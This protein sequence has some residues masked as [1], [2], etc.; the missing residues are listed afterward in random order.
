MGSGVA[1]GVAAGAAGI[2]TGCDPA[3]VAPLMGVWA[4]APWIAWRASLPPRTAEAEAMSEKDRRLLQLT[5]RRTFRFFEAFVGSDDNNLPP[6]NFQEDPKPVIAHRTSPTN[7]GLLLLSTIAAYDFG[8]V[9]LIEMVERLEATL[10]SLQKLQKF[11][12]H[13]FNWHDTKTLEP[14]WPHYVSVVDSGNLAGCFIALQ[15]GCIEIPDNR[16]LDERILKGLTD[17]LGSLQ[18]D[19]SNLS[20]SR[21]RTDSTTGYDGRL[22]SAARNCQQTCDRH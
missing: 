3:L 17:T 2:F 13:F 1:L 15:Q 4:A 20:A 8:Y 9:G 18:Q 11:R 7:I 21:Q 5:A 16:L 10:A 12:G 14:L 22:A 6:D 19:L